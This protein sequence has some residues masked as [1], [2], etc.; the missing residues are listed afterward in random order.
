MQVITV[1]SEKGGTGKTTVA[2]HVAAMLATT[3][4]NVLL[5][6]FDPQGNATVSFGL[7]KEPGLYNLLVR[8]ADIN[9]VL[10]MPQPERYAPPGQAPRGKLYVLPGN[11]ETHGISLVTTDASTFVDALDDVSHYFDVAIIDTAPSPGLLLTL[12][13][14]AT[15]ALIV[16]TQLEHLSLDGLQSTVKAARRAKI[17]IMGVQPMM[18]RDNTD[19]HRHNLNA[20]R[21][22]AIEHDCPVWKPMPMSIVWAEASQMNRMVH[23][24]EGATE[25]SRVYAFE[26]AERVAAGIEQLREVDNG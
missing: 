24:L 14:Q 1:S 13:Y 25:R 7:P 4:M 18:Y 26:M 11:G 15:T 8:G 21:E 20:L 2:T 23:S 9:D 6:D 10:R 16:P 22:W 17:A 5:V 3:G 19:L 12:V